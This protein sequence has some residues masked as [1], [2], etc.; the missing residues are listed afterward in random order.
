MK[1]A[2]SFLVPSLMAAFVAADPFPGANGPV[3][4]PTPG[5]IRLPQPVYDG[6]TSLEKAI[7]ERR[8][9]RHYRNAPI[10]PAQLSQLLWAAQ[11]LT[12]SG[13]RR[14]TP[15]AGALYPL[16]IYAV[17]GNVSGLP[18][19]IYS[20]DPRLHELRRIAAGDA[21]AELSGA[22][23]GQAPVRNGAAVLVISAVYERTTVKYG[24][25]GVRYVH[26]ES[27]HAAQNIHLQAEA[28]GLGTVV[29][30]AFDDDGVRRVLRMSDREHPLCLMPVGKK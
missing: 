9:L 13:S 29:I 10:S 23:L 20:Y 3:P 27:G 14:T 22:A 21:R 17:V 15:S 5:T 18:A 2:H 24:E 19:G 7:G 26:M 6:E 11:G 4:E 28:L 25:R 8:S 30:G 1:F 16:D 12:G